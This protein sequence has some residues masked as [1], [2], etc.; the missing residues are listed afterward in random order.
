MERYIIVQREYEKSIAISLSTLAIS[1][2]ESQS[3]RW[4]FKLAFCGKFLVYGLTFF[5][6]N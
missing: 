5:V 3:P 1:N 2:L 4:T 6:N